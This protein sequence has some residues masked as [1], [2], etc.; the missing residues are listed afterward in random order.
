MKSF[1]QLQRKC[2]HKSGNYNQICMK[3]P[4]T[5]DKCNQ[6]HCPRIKEMEK[7]IEQYP[8]NEPCGETQR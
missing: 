3:I 4:T 6:N 5:N 2:P 8:N 1:K 7:F